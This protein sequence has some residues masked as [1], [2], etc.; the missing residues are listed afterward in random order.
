MSL[1]AATAATE[2]IRRSQGSQKSEL[3]DSIS[4]IILSFRVTEMACA[5][6]LKILAQNRDSLS[7][8]HSLGPRL[9]S[10]SDEKPGHNA[11]ATDK[12]SCLY[13]AMLLCY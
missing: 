6:N 8:N 2:K 9:V 12:G 4:A 7:F 3:Y 11:K 5:E 1:D 13:S 10:S